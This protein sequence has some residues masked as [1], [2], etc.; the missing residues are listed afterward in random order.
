[1]SRGRVIG[2]A[3]LCASLAVLAFASAASALVYWTESGELDLGTSVG[4]AN[5]DG[6]SPNFN[7]LAS[8]ERP[9]GIAVDD[10]YVYWTHRGTT[11]AGIARAKLDGSEVDLNFVDTDFSPCGVAVNDT[12]I[13]WANFGN[14][15]GDTIGRAEIDGENPVQD[16]ISTSNGP[17]GVAVDDEYV[18][19]GHRQVPGDIGRA[20]LDGSEVNKSFITAANASCGVAVNS[21]HLYW[22]EISE[23]Y[24]DGS[25]GRADLDGMN[26]NINFIPNSAGVLS[27]CGVAVDDTYVYWGNAAPMSGGSHIGRAKLDGSAVNTSFILTPRASCGVA[28]TPQTVPEPSC[29][30]LA[31]KVQA[32]EHLDIEL[33]CTAEGEVTYELVDPPANGSLSNFD[34]EAGTV[35]YT[36]GDGYQGPD[37][38]TY[39][40]VNDGGSSLATVTLDVALSNNFK[41]VKVTRNR[42][43]GIATVRAALPGTG[44]LRLA[45]AGIKRASAQ[46]VGPRTVKLTVRAAGR[47][48]KQLRNK[49]KAKVTAKLTYRPLGGDPRTKSKKIRLV[50]R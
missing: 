18:Y 25:V 8:P 30:D 38:F 10:E 20:K 36:P 2:L 49:G 29:N 1:M 33:D 11:S 43:K 42:K 37:S 21:T 19:W 14:I 47:K 22:G 44:T 17:C 26:A 9:C 5:L 48:A 45:G 32:G 41:I 13:Y 16:F 35:R 40:G 3:G 50:K 15:T 28:V 7:W 4:R 46:A 23:F 39:R 12:H 34:A 6:T 27:P 24:G 31:H